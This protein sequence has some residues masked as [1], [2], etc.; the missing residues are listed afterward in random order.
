[1]VSNQTERHGVFKNRGQQFFYILYD[2]ELECG[3]EINEGGKTRQTIELESHLSQRLKGRFQTT[4][5]KSLSNKKVYK[6]SIV[7][8]FQINFIFL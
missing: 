8:F 4:F 2:K 7:G 5:F 6:V 3:G 1:M